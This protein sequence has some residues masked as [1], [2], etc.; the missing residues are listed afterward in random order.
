[1][2]K[3]FLLKILDI[4]SFL[5]HSSGAD[6]AKVRLLLQLKFNLDRRKTPLGFRNIRIKP[7]KDKNLFIYSIIFY[8]F[9]GLLFCGFIVLLSV[10]S[11]LIGSITFFTVLM[12][13]ISYAIILEFS[14]DFFDTSDHDIL[15][16]KPVTLREVNLAKTLHIIIY[17]LGIALAFSIPTLVF[18]AIKFGPAIVIT[19]LFSI[20]FCLLFMFF[21]SALLY[22]SLLKYFSGEKLKDI[23]NMVQILSLIVIFAGYQ[24]FV[25]TSSSWMEKIDFTV[26]PN[27]VYIVP[28]TWFA[29]PGYIAGSGTF[30]LLTLSISIGGIAISVLGYKYYISVLA[31]QFEKNLYKLKLVDTSTAKHRK[32]PALK[33]SLIFRSNLSKAFY[34][35]SVMML[36]R[37]RKIKQA[38]YPMIAMGLIYPVIMIYRLSSDPTIQLI[39]T[40]FYFFMYFNVMMILPLSIYSNYSE[41]FKASWIYR[42]LPVRS[43]GELI[44]TAHMAMFFSYQIV[45]LLTTGLIFLYLWKF[46]IVIHF[47]IIVLNSLIIQL[48][49]QNMAEK[50]LPFSVQLKTGQNTAFKRGAYFLAVFVIVPLTAGLHF[51]STLFNPGVYIFLL[52]QIPVFWILFKNHYSINWKDI[53]G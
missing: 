3:F 43:P 23:I 31:P 19:S 10:K 6:Y 39:N 20:V 12:I 32:P 47:I 53:K 5:F 48:L 40:K 16:P 25:Q 9:M 21:C 27:F 30:D 33:L 45:I 13:F 26:I 35:F 14:L 11:L 50:K 2:K 36:T 49:Y 51:I 29:L 7:G 34:S 4:F 24:I 44:K 37:E 8:G 22:G 18:W 52:I 28:S 46:T 1:M 41:Y 42:F 17:M 15:L 38:V